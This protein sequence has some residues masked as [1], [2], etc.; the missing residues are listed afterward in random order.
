[1]KT[2]G[3][4]LTREADVDEGGL[5][6]TWNRV[7]GDFEKVPL[8][9]EVVWIPVDQVEFIVTERGGWVAM[10]SRIVGRVGRRRVVSAASRE[11]GRW[12]G[13]IDDGVIGV[14]VGTG[15]GRGSPAATAVVIIHGGKIWPRTS[16]WWWRKWRRWR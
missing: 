2:F 1:M 5:R 3:F 11:V 15:T 10:G 14:V 13:T 7:L 4:A 12:T 6:L 16:R 8:A 9:C